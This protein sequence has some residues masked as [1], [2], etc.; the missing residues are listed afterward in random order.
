MAFE[1][2]SI[3]RLSLVLCIAFGELTDKILRLRFYN[4]EAKGHMDG[5]SINISGILEFSF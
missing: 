5:L 2:E 4:R 1:E 3:L